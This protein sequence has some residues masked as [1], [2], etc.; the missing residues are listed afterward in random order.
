MKKIVIALLVSIA[1][2]YF[3]SV[4]K[5]II[6]ELEVTTGVGYD[7][8]GKHKI[9]VT[10]AIPR[11]N[12][13]KSISNH[14]ISTTANL[15]KEALSEVNQKSHKPI[16]NGKLEVVLYNKKIAEQGIQDYIDT[17]HRDPSIGSRLLLTVVD[18]S[19]KK[20]LEKKFGEFDTG[21]YIQ[22]QINHNMKQGLVPTTNLHIFLSA[23]YTKGMDPI[24]PLLE[25]K[26]DAINIK[27]LALF[28]GSRMIKVLPTEK[29]FVFKSL[30]EDLQMAGYKLKTKEE[31]KTEYFSIQGIQ[32]KKRFDIKNIGTDPKITLHLKIK[33]YIREYTGEK[34]TEKTMKKVEKLMEDKLNKEAV[35][36]IK[37]FQKSN[38][39]PLA[40]GDQA[41]SRT[42]NWNEKKW[43]QQYK[44]MKI[45]VKADVLI[46]EI[47]VV[48]GL[49]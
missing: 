33:G 19:T 15:S 6:D 32:S 25:Q 11:I 22:R 12:P 34:V 23:Y 20:M 21:G 46:T 39:D 3:G 2:A 28:K 38:I 18:G 40:I 10:G 31:G 29:M 30:Y 26:G 1:V 45:D 47:G 44:K 17:F 13:D 48:D 35:S 36:M 14:T 9:E 42:R 49:G 43:E 27:G 16:V 5:E 24:L 4:E 41:R 7:Y 37:G 8:K